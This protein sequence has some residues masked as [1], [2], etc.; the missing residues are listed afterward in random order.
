MSKIV[1]WILIMVAI[2]LIAAIPFFIKTYKDF[3]SDPEKLQKMTD[4]TFNN[5]SKS[6]LKEKWDLAEAEAR[7]EVEA[8]EAIKKEKKKQKEREKIIAKN[9]KKMM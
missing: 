2:S 4:D 5:L 1:I 3:M 9:A 7:A 8:E 6:N